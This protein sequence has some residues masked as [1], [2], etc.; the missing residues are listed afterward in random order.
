MGVI[1]RS[2]LISGLIIAA[3]SAH[4]QPG[5][6]PAEQEAPPDAPPT[7]TV[8]ES[9]TV[10]PAD[11]APLERTKTIDL[12]G[13]LG[14][15]YFG[16]N[17]ELGNSWAS[18]Q[19]PGTS[20]VIG[21]RLGVTLVPDLMKG[22]S[23][24]PQLGVEGELAI[25]LGSTGESMDGGRDRYFAP[26]F[27]WRVHG[28][29][30]IRTAGHFHPHLV[31]GVGGESVVSDS[32]FM[33]DDTDAQFYF[34]P[35]LSWH[36]GSESGSLLGGNVRVDLRWGLTAGRTDDPISTVELHIGLERSWDFGGRTVETIKP[37]PLDT[38][39]DGILDDDDACVASPE[40]F[41][42]FEDADGC[43]DTLDKDG[44]GILD[45][46]DDCPDL[47]ETMNEIDD[48]DGCPEFDDDADGLLGS[49]DA[50]PNEAEDFDQY[51]DEDGCP[52]LDNDGDGIPDRS[53]TCPMEPETPNG[54]DDTDG[55]ADEV[56]K[57]VRQF[58]G[59]IGGITFEYSKARI[60]KKSR[61]TLNGAA[62]VL[63]EYPDLRVLIEGHTDN[64]GV[65]AKNMSLSLRRAEAVK[66]YLVDQGIAA[67]RIET[68]G[69][70]PE[71]PLKPNTTKKGRDSNRRIEFHLIIQGGAVTPPAPVEEPTQPP[72]ATPT[73]PP[74]T[75]PPAEAPPPPAPE[76]PATQ[77]TPAPVP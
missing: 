23:V 35:G 73:P 4:A 40:T 22:S 5:A 24:D 32:P 63:R 62:A 10:A 59:V 48:A 52:E 65:L 20:F 46:D 74:A 54:F 71:R 38:D 43:P 45:A 15:H 51:L 37:I 50:C 29:A 58:T 36:R 25:A 76:A 64:K 30:R 49:K 47:P 77:P 1:R 26:V 33:A 27:G 28:I 60:Q 8:T 55:C 42:D 16:D 41:N 56:P 13:F 61:K 31:I 39:G 34:G 44:D 7:E 18:E 12:G 21:G 17:I 67:D 72:P 69:I 11:D 14:L 68:A 3:P 53:D 19:V 66:W 6:T 57:I 70:G 75:P 2:A 9:T